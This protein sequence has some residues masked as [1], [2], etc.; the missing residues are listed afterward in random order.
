MTGADDHDNGDSFAKLATADGV[1]CAPIACFGPDALALLGV[2]GCF[3]H[4]L[5]TFWADE[6]E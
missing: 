2:A 1:F 6:M 5:L 3:R 4:W